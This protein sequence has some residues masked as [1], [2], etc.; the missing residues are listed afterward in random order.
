MGQVAARTLKPKQLVAQSEIRETERAVRADRLTTVQE[1]KTLAEKVAKSTVCHK[2]FY[3]AELRETYKYH[4]RMK[5]ID[6]VFPYARLGDDETTSVL[7]IDTPQT[8]QDV[9][10][11]YLK[12]PILDAHGYKYAVIEK[13]SDLYGVLT[14]IG[15][16]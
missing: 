15:A 13:D 16:V 9:E 5:R 7:L 3:P 14:Q 6:L 4:D 10:I 8:E 12:K 1:F 11:C 2:N